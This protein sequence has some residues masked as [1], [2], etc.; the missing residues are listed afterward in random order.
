MRAAAILESARA[1]A[2]GDRLLIAPEA[3]S[4]HYSGDMVRRDAP[5]GATWMTREERESDIADYV[6]YLDSVHA[7]QQERSG[8]AAPPVTLLGFSQGGAT[9]VRWLA[10]GDVRAAHLIV[11]ASSLPTDVDLAAL[12]A[13][14]GKPRVTYVCGTRDRWITTKVLE[15]QHQMLRDAGVPFIPVAFEG[16]HRLDDDALRI[17]AAQ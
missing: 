13:K 5:V 6:G 14:Q 15:A 8:G 7:L 2:S 16:G 10:R 17:V 12:Y 1:V 4:R 11:W 3:L 9:A